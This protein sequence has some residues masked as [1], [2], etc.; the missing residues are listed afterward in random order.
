[1][2]PAGRGARRI[3]RVVGFAPGDSSDDFKNFLRIEISNAS[4]HLSTLNMLSELSKLSELNAQRRGG[5]ETIHRSLGPWARIRREGAG[6]T[7]WQLRE[8]Y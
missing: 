4:T 7:R 8:I 6:D 2:R 5:R 1:M 3:F